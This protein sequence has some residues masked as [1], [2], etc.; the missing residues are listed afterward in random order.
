MSKARFILVLAFVAVVLTACGTAQVAPTATATLPPTEAV[1][2]T[3]FVPATNT[4]APTA[5]ATLTPTPDY[6]L[7][8]MGPSNFADTIDPLTGL[9]VEDPALLNRRPI[10]IKVQNLPREDRPQYGLSK[11]DIVYEYY[12]EFGTTRF[13][14]VFYGQDASQ[15]MPIRS[16]RMSDVNYVQMYKGVFV[17]GSAYQTVYWKL[18]NSDFANRL[19]L[20]SGSSCPA[21]CRYDPSGHNYL[22][23]DTAALQSYLTTR[24]VDNTRQNLDGMFF[25]KVLPSGG[26]P[27]DQVFVR[28]SGAIY[29]RWDYDAASG[30]YLR[31]AE[32][33][34]DTSGSNPVYAQLTDALTKE[35]ISA[36]NVVMLQVKHSQLSTD[37]TAEVIDYSLIGSG[38]AYLA[39]DGKLFKVKWE[40][41]TTTDVLHLVDE[42]GNDIAFKPGNTW[43]EVLTLNA[44]AAQDG[45]NWKFSF[46]SDW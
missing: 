35:P 46:V 30:K 28:F 36:D 27:A 21:V 31:F 37:P 24:G 20:E 4:P 42:N 19:I 25:N 5:T 16:A 17:F 34:N 22:V 32:T 7:E 12:T 13:A 43:F 39:R 23:A 9:E 41:E 40:R 6:P 44:T 14:A 11:A 2:D 26:T 8:G 3:P 33:Q 1:L 38:D 29:N 45:N 10:V 15:V 18:A